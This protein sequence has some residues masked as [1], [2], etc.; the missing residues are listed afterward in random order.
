MYLNCKSWFSL[1]YGTIRTDE[2]VSAAKAH[3]ITS[4]A[5]TN[6]NATT[7]AWLFVQECL[8]ADIKP[9]LGL[10]CRNGAAFRYILLARDMDG[11]L[12]INRFYLRI[13]Y[14][15]NHSRKKPRFSTRPL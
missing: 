13:C 3:G 15:V 9:I 6:I 14:Q 4:L 1:R 8:Q 2:L 7:D 11:W 12:A 5:L 10:E